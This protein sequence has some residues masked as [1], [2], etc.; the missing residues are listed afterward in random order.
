M[1]LTM[2][3]PE[4]DFR[5]NNEN[6]VLI[7]A[8]R[9]TLLTRHTFR[10][11]YDT[12]GC[13]VNNPSLNVIKRYTPNVE[14]SLSHNNE[15]VLIENDVFCLH[16]NPNEP[17]YQ[18]LRVDI[19]GYDLPYIH[20]QK[21]KR[22]LK[23]TARTLDQVNGR[24]NLNDGYFSLDGYAIIDD[25]DTPIFEQDGNIKERKLSHTDFIFIAGR[26]EF[27]EV[28]QELI[29]FLGRVPKFPRFVLGNW[30]SKYW[31]YADY[32]L[33]DVVDQFKKLNIPLSVCIVDMDWHLTDLPGH[34]YWYGWTGYTV[35][36]T[37]FPDF[38]DFI[39]QLH[40]QSIRTSV[41]LHP[42]LGIR[43]H[44]VQ[45]KKFCEW[46]NIDPSMKQTIPFAIDDPHFRQGY[47]E[48]LHH[49][50]EEQGV[51]FW[52]IDWQQGTTSN[53][54]GVDP[55]F[56][57]NHF[58]SLDIARN[59][60]RPFAF[61]RWT[62]QGGHRTPIGFSGDTVSTWDSLAFQPYFTATSANVNFSW[63]SHDIGGHYQGN[64]EPELL[65]RWVQFGVFSPIL[66]LHSSKNELAVREP[67]L[68]GQ[69][70]QQVI[71]EMM[72][73]RV[74]LIPYFYTGLH[75]NSIQGIPFLTP[76][77]YDYPLDPQTYKAKNTY[78][79]GSSLL[80][81]PVITPIVS[82]LNR[83][84][85]KVYLPKG[86]WIHFFTNIEYQGGRWIDCYSPIE[87][88][89]V[90]V[91]KG[92]ILPLAM[93]ESQDDVC[94]NPKTLLV[95]VYPD[96]SASYTLIEDDNETQA[97]LMNDI[98]KI[99]ITYNYGALSIK[100]DTKMQHYCPQQRNYHI[101][102]IGYHVQGNFK[103]VNSKDGTFI[104]LQCVDC[105][106]TVILTFDK[107][108]CVDQKALIRNQLKFALANV[109][110]NVDQKRELLDA[111]D[112]GKMKKVLKDMTLDVEIIE[113][114]KSIINTKVTST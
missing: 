64:E 47:F 78:L 86:Q 11:E 41:N 76:L 37:Y 42:A 63:W 49:P 104:E 54:Q 108:D 93:W 10:V 33:L 8:F 101:E 112:T 58:H 62:K 97:Y 96:E 17:P 28:H 22:N 85:T 75:L 16:F 4:L 14:F 51:D 9:I 59:G 34:D 25:H 71:A 29:T 88:L 80:V 6:T 27:K 60:Q 109:R 105:T 82:K 24:L 107:V 66:R 57:L 2:I 23:G 61:S 89:P 100:P 5:I 99:E 77:Y 32:E 81:S 20:G 45:Y 36:P 69:P 65:T 73:L 7:G 95:K 113:L 72:R 79:L 21:L 39:S 12:Q 70:H 18:N 92:S 68:M 91:R 114:V 38:K 19:K 40:S 35:N 13:F 90:F 87:H 110:A 74:R 94:D 55:L 53:T 103:S 67:W 84:K 52:W 26:N 46:M 83:A 98:F 50:Y 31:N 102:I 48:I 106:S 3:H 43:P 56:A 111:F 30:W 15:N 1:R 44:E